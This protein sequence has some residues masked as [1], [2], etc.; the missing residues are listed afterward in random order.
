ML[1]PLP[2]IVD[3]DA[4][5]KHYDRHIFKRRIAQTGTIMVGRNIYYV[6]YKYAGKAVGVL[7]DAQL[8]TLRVLHKGNVLREL[9]IE[10]LVGK[11]MPFQD[12]LTYMLQEAR[13]PSN[14]KK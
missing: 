13:T 12:Y 10:G 6:D 7:L 11:T 1:R 14:D 3:P 2:E 5:L 4:W 9:D 8:G